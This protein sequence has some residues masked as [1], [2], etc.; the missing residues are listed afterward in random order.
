MAETL[1]QALGDIFGR[2]LVSALAP[3]RLDSSATSVVQTAPV[4]EPGAKPELDLK[5]PTLA[6]LAAEA[7]AHYDRM[8]KAQR[9]GDWALYGEELKKLGD[10]LAKMRKLK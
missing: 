3:D 6:E 1:N 2:G 8:A 5:D 10:V 7:S 9:D 4:P